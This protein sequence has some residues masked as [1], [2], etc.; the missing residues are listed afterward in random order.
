[1]SG[2]DPHF[3]GVHLPLPTVQPD[4]A[5]DLL[6]SEKLT[7][8]VLATYPN[9]AVMTDKARRA[10]ILSVLQIERDL[11][12]KTSRT[13][14]WKIDSRVGAENQL[15]NAYYTNN[16]WDRGH[17]ARRESAGWGQSGRDAQKASDETFYF[18]NAC[19]QHENVNQDEWLVLEDWAQKGAP[20][21]DGKVVEFSGPIYGDFVRSIRPTGR[22]PGDVPT[23]FFKVICFINRDTNQLDVRAF[24][25][26]QDRDSMRD[27]DGR[28]A[29]NFQKYQVTIKE[30]EE[31][32]GLDFPDEVYEKNPLFFHPSVGAQNLGVTSFPERVDVNGP[33]DVIT[34][35]VEPRIAVRDDDVEVYIS[36][37]MV[38]PPGADANQEWVSILNL[39]TDPV[40]LQGWRLIDKAKHVR[41]LDGVLRPGE[42]KVF[43]GNAGL[44]PVK[45]GNQGGVLTLINAKNERIDRVDYTDKDVLRLAR[46]KNR[47]LP[48]IFATYRTEDP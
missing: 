27:K 31:L 37:A 24:L 23:G 21:K 4:R 1:M 38:D 17:M 28:K 44:A 46:A 34:S 2:Y 6:I 47:T 43:K 9:Y 25:L 30:I 32:A 36:A 19:L 39:E 18:S 3:L 45:L 14:K 20:A 29:F 8:Q 11:L 22:A 33:E 7:D 35:S 12:K 5:G 42:A 26:L 41:P 40:D 16:P 48:I 15:D 13:D 10:P